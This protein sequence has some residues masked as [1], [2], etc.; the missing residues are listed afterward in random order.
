MKEKSESAKGRD[1]ANTTRIEL[2]HRDI[3]LVIVSVG[4]FLIGYF[5][6]ENPT[7]FTKEALLLRPDW[8]N[9]AFG[10]I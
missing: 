1:K 3:I 8:L 7:P 9:V 10:N 6:M 4:I 2:Y 5:G